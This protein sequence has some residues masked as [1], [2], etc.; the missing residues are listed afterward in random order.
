MVLILFHI[1]S[2]CCHNVYL[3]IPSLEREA[4]R[5]TA[6]AAPVGDELHDVLHLRVGHRFGHHDELVPLLL[7]GHQAVVVELELAVEHGV[8]G[9]QAGWG[10]RARPGRERGARGRQNYIKRGREQ[11]HVECPCVKN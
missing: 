8:A 1:S 10:S 7:D 2:I 6:Q 3:C 4:W 11:C 5:G 9:H